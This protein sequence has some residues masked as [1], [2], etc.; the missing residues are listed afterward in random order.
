[1]L[2]ATWKWGFEPAFLEKRSCQWHGEL[3]PKSHPVLS[4]MGKGNL[5]PGSWISV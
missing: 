3:S 5:L 2:R 4:R 1:M